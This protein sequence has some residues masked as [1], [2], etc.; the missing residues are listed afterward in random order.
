MKYLPLCII[1]L[2]LSSCATSDFFVK[3]PAKKSFEMDFPAYEA[4]DVS[5]KN[6]SLTD[7]DVEVQ[8]KTTGSFF[9]GFGLGP[10]AK[11]TVL[12]EKEGKL[13]L[14]NP[15]NFSVGV[16]ARISESR[17]EPIDPN[18]NTITFTL[19]NNTARSIPLLIP[20]VMNPNLSPFSK[21]VV[22]LDIGQEILFRYKRKKYVLLT[23]S[24]DIRDGEIIEVGRMLKRRKAELG[25]Q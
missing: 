9:R 22:D 18:L 7:V 5:L 20:S 12:V 8:D 16:K 23:V 24:S 14:A 21:S 10:R 17:P 15:S 11:A 3:I 2:V 13:I 25:L 19:A 6:K 1:C 4:Y